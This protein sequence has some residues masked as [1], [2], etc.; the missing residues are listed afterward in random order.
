VAELAEI[1]LP[2]AALDATMTEIGT[3]A[4]QD[5]GTGRVGAVIVVAR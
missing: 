1:A 4:Y 3:A 2:D 5:A